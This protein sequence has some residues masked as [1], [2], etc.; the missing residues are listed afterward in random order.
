M[1]ASSSCSCKLT[2]SFTFRE[3][4]SFFIIFL[5]NRKHILLNENE[6][7]LQNTLKDKQ[8][9]WIQFNKP[10]VYSVHAKEKK[11]KRQ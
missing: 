5:E 8:G 9:I 10:L 6:N 2:D 7:F 11:K 3:F 1:A 4:S